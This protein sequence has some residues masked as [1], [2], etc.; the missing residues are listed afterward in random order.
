MHYVGSCQGKQV[1]QQVP[2][3]QYNLDHPILGEEF[4]Y[5]H[6]THNAMDRNAVAV[7]EDTT[8]LML[9]IFLQFNNNSNNTIQEHN[10]GTGQNKAIIIT[11]LIS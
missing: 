11:A 4:A 10:T 7:V 5:E 1:Y 2:R 3:L 9:F 8:G 6:E